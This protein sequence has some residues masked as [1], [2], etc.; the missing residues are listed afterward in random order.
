[1]LTGFILE[2]FTPGF[3]ITGAAGALALLIFTAG[4]VMSG[5]AGI[6]TV[7]LIF[8]G[9]LFI[10]AEAILPGG[11]VGLIGFSLFLR[12]FYLPGQLALDGDFINHRVF[13]CGSS[14]DI[15]DKGVGERNEIF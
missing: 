5:E 14:I 7:L 10:L 8:F 12:A 1:M 15:N 2:L 11:I 9:V 4:H 13:Y 3:G 6:L